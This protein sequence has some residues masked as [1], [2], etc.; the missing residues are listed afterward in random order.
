[1]ACVLGA[2]FLEKSG[3]KNMHD[4]TSL[5][6]DFRV[7]RNLYELEPHQK[8]LR[9]KPQ[10]IGRVCNYSSVYLSFINNYLSGFDKQ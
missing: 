4:V 7:R 6:D 3:R 8:A 9:R 5:H 10:R 1:M 2:C